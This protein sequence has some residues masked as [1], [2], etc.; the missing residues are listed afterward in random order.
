VKGYNGVL[1]VNNAASAD[2]LSQLS[3]LSAA[4]TRRVKDL[5]AQNASTKVINQ[6][7]KENENRILA[8]IEP[9]FKS[10]D[11]AR[12]FA[13][14]I[15]LIPKAPTVTPKFNDSAARKRAGAFAAYLDYVSR[16]RV[17][18]IRFNTRGNAQAAAG[19]P[20]GGFDIATNA[21]GGFLPAGQ[22][23]WV[24]EKGPELVRFG[25][26]GR[27]YSNDESMDM[28]KRVNTLDSMTGSGGA[29]RVLSATN[30]SPSK[31]KATVN[32]QTTPEVYVYI[33]GKEVRAIV[34]TEMDERDR[35]LVQ[36][37]DIGT[38]RRT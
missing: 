36:L 4:G 2:V 14:Q 23:S 35:R 19:I 24:G 30:A 10:R 9:F 21:A 20:T 27:V 28:V 38:G 22:W 26:G 3:E 25:R 33:D 1:D 18:T 11:A 37:V 7:I 32:V 29:N 12:K 17:A 5:Q 16:D 15:G 6:T 31:L 34:K 8:L 13:E